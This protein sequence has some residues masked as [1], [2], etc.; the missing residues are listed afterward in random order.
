LAL[1]ALH[2]VGVSNANGV[3]WLQEQ[4]CADGSWT[5]FRA[6]TAAPCPA[7][8]P[9]TFSGADTNSTALAVLGLHAQAATMA[10]TH[11]IDALNAVR[12]A[13]G[14]WGFLSRSDQATD[15]NSTGVVLAALRTVNG[16][17]DAPGMAALLALQAGCSADAAD[18]G[19]VAYQPGAGGTLVPAPVATGRTTPPPAARPA[20]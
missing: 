4:Q 14:G 9:A 13:S 6:D 18:R 15:A 11:G 8:D 19:G 16:T 1:L 2:A 20:P 17:A 7:V 5:A 12:N 10:V 3:T